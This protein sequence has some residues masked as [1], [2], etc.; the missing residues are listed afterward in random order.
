MEKTADSG[1][2]RDINVLLVI[3]LVYGYIIK[4]QY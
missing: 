2:T 4:D 1:E 3:V